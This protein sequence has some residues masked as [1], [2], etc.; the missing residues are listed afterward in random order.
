MQAGATYTNALSQKYQTTSTS[1]TIV[2]QY[3]KPP[4]QTDQ[5]ITLFT[6]DAKE[7]PLL[8]TDD[9]NNHSTT[10]KQKLHTQTNDNV[11]VM[12]TTSTAT[13]PIDLEALQREIKKSIQDN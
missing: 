3:C 4:P 13:T 10:D 9:T 12:T 11:T 5:K 6:F 8:N 1:P 2:T 7:F